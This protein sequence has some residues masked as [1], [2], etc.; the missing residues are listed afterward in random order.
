MTEKI[1]APSRL[2]PGT[3]RSAGKSYR[4]PFVIKI[5][6]ATFVIIL[7]SHKIIMECLIF[8]SPSRISVFI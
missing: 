8:A 7:Q 6:H 5:S 2:E 4:A 1:P 3:A